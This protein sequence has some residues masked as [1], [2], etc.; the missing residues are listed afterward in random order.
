MQCTF[1][2]I[3]DIIKIVFKYYL[4]TILKL[5]TEQRII[6]KGEFTLVVSGETKKKLTTINKD[7]KRKLNELLKKYNLTEAVKIVHSL[8]GISRKDIYTMAL[9]LKND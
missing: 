9:K 6:L 5:L 2:D 7:I 3:N 4:N 8:T 1:C